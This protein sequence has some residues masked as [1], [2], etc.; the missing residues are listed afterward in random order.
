MNLT[1]YLFVSFT[2]VSFSV[3]MIFKLVSRLFYNQKKQY[4]RKSPRNNGRPIYSI[5][6]WEARRD[7]GHHESYLADLDSIH[8][9]VY[10]VVFLKS[11]VTLRRD[12]VHNALV[13]LSRKHPLLRANV[14]IR[15]KGYSFYENLHDCDMRR[16]QFVIREA[17][18]FRP[19][20]R[21][22][23][24]SHWKIVLE[25]EFL[26]NRKN[27]LC[28]PLWRTILLR[29]QYH[30]KERLYINSLLFFFDQVIM[31]RRSI[32]PFIEDFTKFLCKLVNC[33]IHVD[34]TRP[35]EM[36]GPSEL[37]L[38]DPPFWKS[39]IFMVHNKLNKL[40][41]FGSSLEMYHRESKRRKMKPLFLTQSL[42]IEET[43]RLFHCCRKMKCSLISVFV[44]AW[45]QM[46]AGHSANGNVPQAVFKKLVSVVMDYRN[47]LSTPF[48]SSYLGN[49]SS[50]IVLHVSV[51]QQQRVNFWSSVEHCESLLNSAMKNEEHLDFIWKLKHCNRGMVGK[52]TRRSDFELAD[53]GQFNLI[54]TH[55]FSLEEIYMGASGV[56]EATLTL[57]VINNK[58][59]CGMHLSSDN[60][61]CSGFL[62]VLL[63]VIE[64]H[65][66]SQLA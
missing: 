44:A 64:H 61:E 5:Q 30:A 8:S 36:Q 48:P 50:N 26:L 27:N 49:S 40:F 20:L 25:E 24:T 11:A 39:L 14:D 47:S 34:D 57:V 65:V 33:D 16:K 2:I 23:N 13:L 22:V 62:K 37:L 7:M 38:K 9:K 19:E 51:D 60:S 56:S 58:L 46:H 66:C 59:Y 45:L 15:V 43:S 12:T 41:S 32:V 31:D 53:V 52:L 29:E 4:C 54:R 63:T 35:L 55:P 21:F 17:R 6:E 28:K 3:Y 42:S 1:V 18:E 10:A